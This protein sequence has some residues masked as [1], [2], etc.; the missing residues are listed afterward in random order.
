[1]R[2]PCF[3][4]DQFA[5]LETGLCFCMQ[6]LCLAEAEHLA[7]FQHAD[8]S[9]QACHIIPDD[10]YNNSVEIKRCYCITNL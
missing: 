8:G 4:H 7:C 6:M 9:S 1:M 10:T 2:S 5:S 3:S